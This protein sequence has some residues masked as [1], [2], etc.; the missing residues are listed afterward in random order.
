MKPI[1]FELVDGQ[2]FMTPSIEIDGE[3]LADRFDAMGIILFDVWWEELGC[4][5][6]SVLSD[7]RFIL[8]VYNELSVVDFSDGHQ[9][10]FLGDGEIQMEVC[11]SGSLTR[12]TRTYSPGLQANRT[13]IRHYEVSTESYVAAW[14]GLARDIIDLP[15]NPDAQRLVRAK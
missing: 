12:I 1:R 2:G 14:V 9:T 8:D 3:Q 5:V 10:I 13:T 6:F 4:L 11:L 7:V 15:N